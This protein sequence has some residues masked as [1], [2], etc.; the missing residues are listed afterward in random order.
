MTAVHSVTN[1][2]NE[3]TASISL[4]HTS[5]QCKPEIKQSQTHSW[6]TDRQ[7]MWEQITRYM[8]CQS[9]ISGL[10]Q[11]NF[12]LT[13]VTGWPCPLYNLYTRPSASSISLCIS[14]SPVSWFSPAHLWCG[15][16]LCNILQPSSLTGFSSLGTGY[17]RQAFSV[18]F[19]LDCHALV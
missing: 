7:G 6:M 14:G 2:H 5:I 1:V 16:N 12:R 19:G 4:L 15:V 8:S 18:L 11:N 10:G 17:L 3:P 9:K 13:L